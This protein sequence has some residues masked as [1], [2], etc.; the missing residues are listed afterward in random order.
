MEGLLIHLDFGKPERRERANPT[1]VEQV[2]G[3]Q[4]ASGPDDVGT[5]TADVLTWVDGREDA[6]V[7]R[8]RRSVSSTITTASAPSGIGAPVAISAASPALRRRVGTS[9]V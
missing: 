6:H 2:A 7:V 5:L 3:S 9:P 4:N 1:G 8:R